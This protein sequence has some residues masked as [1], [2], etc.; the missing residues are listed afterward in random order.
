MR[1]AAKVLLLFGDA[2]PYLLTARGLLCNCTAADPAHCAATDALTELSMP[3]R[4]LQ[5][6]PM[7]LLAAFC[8]ITSCPHGA[9]F[10]GTSRGSCLAGSTCADK[11]HTRGQNPVAQSR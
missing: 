4:A 11:I 3:V 6:G 7:S 1:T 2:G 8:R 10:P 5:R 9:R